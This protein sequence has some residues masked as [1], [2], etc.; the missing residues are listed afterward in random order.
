[1]ADAGEVHPNV[2]VTVKVRVPAARPLIVVFRPV[3]AMAPGLIVQFP[4]GKP[5]KTTF[6]VATEHV[7]CVIVPTM[8]AKGVASIS[9]TLADASDVH[10]TEFVTV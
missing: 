8:G 4:V 2:L 5:L 1:M 9:T 7:G 10:P 3:P 6:P